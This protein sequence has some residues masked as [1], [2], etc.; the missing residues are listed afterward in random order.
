M[1]VQPDPPVIALEPSTGE[2]NARD[3]VASLEQASLQTFLTMI[4]PDVDAIKRLK[5]VNLNKRNTIRRPAANSIR[6]QVNQEMANELDEATPLPAPSTGSLEITRM[7]MTE[8]SLAN[9]RKTIK[10]VK[11]KKQQQQNVE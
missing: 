9:A 7:L 11:K 4:Q 10:R 5:P 6:E 8:G 1:Q 2:N 3:S